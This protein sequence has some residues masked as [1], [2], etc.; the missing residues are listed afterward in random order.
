MSARSK[1]R[2]RQDSGQPLTDGEPRWPSQ[3]PRFAIP[4]MPDHLKSVFPSGC[5]DVY[6]DE[7][8]QNLV[9]TP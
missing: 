6:V 4:S 8:Q 5:G 2:L 9:V 7:D 3:K 1:K